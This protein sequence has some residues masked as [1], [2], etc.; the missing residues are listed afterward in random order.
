MKKKTQTLYSYT[1]LHHRR[2]ELKV[3]SITHSKEEPFVRTM[4]DSDKIKELEE[5]PAS[6]KD[7]RFVILFLQTLFEIHFLTAYIWFI[8]HMY[9]IGLAF[10]DFLFVREKNPKIYS[11]STMHESSSYDVLNGRMVQIFR[12]RRS[13]D[14]YIDINM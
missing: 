10:H 11:D 9:A 6:K 13:I 14:L 12:H 4:K 3:K 8:L 7:W 1:F 2:R 5:I